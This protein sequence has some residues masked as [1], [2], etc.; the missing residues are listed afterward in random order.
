[1][2][3]KLLGRTLAA[4]AVSVTSLACGGGGSTGTDAG[5]DPIDAHLPPFDGGTPV[6]FPVPIDLACVITLSPAQ[7]VAEMAMTADGSIYVRGLL[8]GDGDLDPGP[9]EEPYVRPSVDRA[10]SFVARFEPDC[11]YAWTRVLDL[12]LTLDSLDVDAAGTVVIS[13]LANDDAAGGGVSVDFDPTPGNDRRSFA[14]GP[15]V[16]RF[17][18]DGSYVSTVLPRIC[19]P[20]LDYCYSALRDR[21]M[22]PDGTLIISAT[23]GLVHVGPDGTVGW[24]GMAPDAGVPISGNLELGPDGAIYVE[25]P[26]GDLDWTGGFD[27]PAPACRA[28]DTTCPERRAITRVEPDGTYGGSVVQPP[29]VSF[30]VHDFAIDGDGDLQLVGIVHMGGGYVDL[31][32]GPDYD[33]VGGWAHYGSTLAPDGALRW[34]TLYPT[35]QT[36]TATFDQPRDGT[37]AVDREGGIVYRLGRYAASLGTPTGV[38]FADDNQYDTFLDVETTEGRPLWSVTLAAPALYSN[39]GDIAFE[40]GSNGRFAVVLGG[41][42]LDITE[43][44]R[45]RDGDGVTIAVYEPERCTDGETR[46]TL[47]VAG[48]SSILTCAG[49][50]W[51]PTECTESWPDIHVCTRSC[52]EQS[53]TGVACGTHDDGCGGMVSCGTCP[54]P[55]VCGGAGRTCIGP[56]SSGPIATGLNHP[57]Y[58]MA[59]DAT[60]V[61]F[62]EGGDLPPIGMLHGE[63]TIMRVPRDGSAPPTTIA[64]AGPNVRF[65][66]SPTHLYMIDPAAGTFSRAP[67]DGSGP[68]ETIAT[69]LRNAGDVVADGD[70]FVYYTTELESEP[71]HPRWLYAYDQQT[72]FL[73]RVEG[74]S[75]QPS[76]LRADATNI[77]VSAVPAPPDTVWYS[78]PRGELGLPRPE[79]LVGTRMALVAID[80]VGR[81]VYGTVPFDNGLYRQAFGSGGGAHVL[82]HTYADPVERPAQRGVVDGT[83]VWWAEEGEWTARTWSGRVRYADLTTG[84]SR[85]AYTGLNHVAAIAGDAAGLYAAVRGDLSVSTD[86]GQIVRIW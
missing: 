81:M 45:M 25:R 4:L 75:F 61:Y 57:E 73:A 39:I 38:F 30:T 83:G 23:G 9:A 13:G 6:G 48:G 76:S 8:I 77:Y 29:P 70:T 79:L 10:Q 40:A 82:V 85:I 12:A 58:Q 14:G 59:L 86:Q 71:T 50:R 67:N 54:A 78:W 33:L 3:R 60:H 65:D 27:S 63:V 55:M 31:D 24:P 80:P 64:T 74:L 42:D 22:R 43:G 68:V 20:A 34:S 26:I 36:T 49:G 41:S 37:I 28:G 44:T 56:T 53:I 11:T 5:T 66:V 46:P 2:S 21:V 62:V 35:G 32:F 1:M 17:G 15:F 19:D 18:P 47:C 69:G 7:S 52:A 72:T 51:G 84:E 16:S